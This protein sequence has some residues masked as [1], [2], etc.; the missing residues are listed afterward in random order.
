[1]KRCRTLQVELVLSGGKT[2]HYKST[3]RE[4]NY[5]LYLLAK[6]HSH[7]NISLFTNRRLK[8][9]QTKD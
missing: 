1:M 5:L 6:Q 3:T 8:L 4:I 7:I 2:K 9:Q